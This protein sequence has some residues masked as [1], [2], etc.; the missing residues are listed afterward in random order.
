MTLKLFCKN[1]IVIMDHVIEETPFSVEHYTFSWKDVRKY[2]AGLIN[3]LPAKYTLAYFNDY[4]EKIIMLI[5]EDNNFFG[6]QDPQIL[7][8]SKIDND[9]KQSMIAFEIKHYRGDMFTREDFDKGETAM[10]KITGY[11]KMFVNPVSN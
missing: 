7:V 9:K 5:N 3:R 10:K 4:H 2:T 8:I 6:I 11:L 1:K